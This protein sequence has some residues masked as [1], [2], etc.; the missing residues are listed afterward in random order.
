[1]NQGYLDNVIGNSPVGLTEQETVVYLLCQ[2]H[3]PVRI[4]QKKS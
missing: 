2:L 4:Q 3:C 1:L